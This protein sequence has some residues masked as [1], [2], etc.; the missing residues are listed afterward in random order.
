MTNVEAY[1]LWKKEY[2]DI[3]IGKSKFAALRPP[4]V[5]L[6]IELPRNVC[7]CRY[8]EN[9][10]L[11]WDALHKFNARFPSYHHELASSSICAESTD[12]CWYN[13]CEICKDGVL[14]TR[15]AHWS[16]AQVTI[17]TAIYW[18]HDTSKSPI[19]VS[20]DIADTKHS[21]VV[22]LETT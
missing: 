17:L 7:V 3:K 4:H 19:I 8:H 21:V 14:H 22:F 1:S 18:H 12:N 20:D 15:S 2:P 16:K 13:K 9:F 5:L 6:T 11:L 10:I